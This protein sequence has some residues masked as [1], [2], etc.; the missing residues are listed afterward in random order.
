MV[1]LI[2][3]AIVWFVG[4][5]VSY[6]CFMSKWEDNPKY[7]RYYFAFIWPLTGILYIPYFIHNYNRI[8]HGVKRDENYI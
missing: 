3:I 2:I 1:T 5:F 8:V 6:K 7:E 4:I